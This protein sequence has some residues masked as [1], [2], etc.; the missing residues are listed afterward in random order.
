MNKFSDDRRRLAEALSDL[1]GSAGL[2]TTQL[3]H[4]LGWS[5]SK[6]SKTERGVTLPQPSD[7]EAW[8]VATKA[9]SKLRA[10]LSALADRMAVEFTEWR[11]TLA[12]GPRRVQQ[13]IQRLEETASVVRVFNPNVVVGLAQTRAYIEA[14][15]RL[16]PGA[17]VASLDHAVAARLARQATLTDGRK[18]FELVMGEAAL[19]RRLIGPAAMRNQLERLVELSRQPN[20]GLGV[21]RFD[22]DERVHQHHGYSVIGDPDLD[23]DAIVWAGTV[24]RTLRVRGDTEVRE[25]VEHFDGLRAAATEGEPLRAFLR[26]L[27]AELP[28]T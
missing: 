8:A 27:I 2:S 24:T 7:V 20:I 12:P 23:N 28:E 17:L 5:Q 21:I 22:A 3:A 9:S 6:V 13:E 14:M 15:F 4:Q 25:Y 18:R 19:R 1:R 16:G 10:E 11:R 26:E